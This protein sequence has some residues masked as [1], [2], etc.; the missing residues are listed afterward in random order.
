MA[1]RRAARPRGS[2]NPAEQALLRKLHQTIRK[3][4]QDFQGR[5]HFNTCIAAIMELVN[6]LTAADA[7]LSKGEVAPEVLAEIL[8]SLILLLAPF[9]PFLSAELW[10]EIG[11]QGSILRT[12][13]AEV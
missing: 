5:W 8:R 13:V 1:W 7:A 10:Q 9:A 11:G 4:T 2:Q 12:S 6:D 3:I